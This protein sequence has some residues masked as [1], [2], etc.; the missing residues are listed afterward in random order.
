MKERQDHFDRVGW[1]GCGVLNPSPGGHHPSMH[2][3]RYGE[4]VN[5]SEVTLKTALAFLAEDYEPRML[6]YHQHSI[7]L[8]SNKKDRPPN[9][10]GTNHEAWRNWKINASPLLGHNSFLFV[11]GV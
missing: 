3:L 1:S 5:N 2:L 4:L 7:S 8:Y 11:L 10:F 6:D 9:A